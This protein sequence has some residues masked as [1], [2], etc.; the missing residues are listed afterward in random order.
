MRTGLRKRRI[1]TVF[2]LV[3]FCVFAASVLVVL[4]LGA[5]IYQSMNDISQQERDERTALAF[6]W[7]KVKNNDNAGV[8]SVGEFEGI[9]ALFYDE[10]IGERVF[11]T[12]IYLYDGW[13]TEL[14]ADPLL[15]LSP[16]DGVHIMELDDLSFDELDYGLIRVSAGARS[17][18]LSPRGTESNPR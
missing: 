13:V 8:L 9:S 11:R 5:G 16:S 6:I 14:F 18:L 2:V 12:A 15:G 17:L 1:D 10:I 3:V 7:T 4:I